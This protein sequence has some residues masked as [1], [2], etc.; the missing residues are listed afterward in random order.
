MPTLI[1]NPAGIYHIV[2]YKKG[3]RIWRSLSTRDHRLAKIRFKEYEE[4]GLNKPTVRIIDTPGRTTND[5]TLRQVIDEYLLYVKSNFSTNTYTDYVS[6]MKL[7]S[8]FFGPEIPV[9]TITIRDIER[10]KISK[11]DGILSPHT[12]NHNLRCIKA[13]FNLLVR[14]SLIDKSPCT[15]VSQLR[16]DDTIRPYLQREELQKILSFTTGT[17]LYPIII[18]AVLTGLRLGEIV[19]FTWDDIILEQRK[20]IVRSK[21]NFRTKTGKLRTIPISSDLYNLLSEMPDKTGLLFKQK[22]GKPFRDEF[23]SK[24]FKTA[25]RDCKLNPKL[26]FHSLRHTFGSYLV[27]QGV[28]L[29]HVQQLMGHSS[30][31]VTQIY[32]HLGCAELMESVEK[33]KVFG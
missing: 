31:F 18:F 30:P 7:F 33:I 1:K 3:K 9:R 23:I 16:T 8:L 28:S 29:F 11:N 25:V 21:S 6:I 19:N 4:R 24:Q 5:I 10:Y 22:D 13:F 2:F 17:Y 14:W 32:A 20:I 12:V 15:G 26:H 27:V